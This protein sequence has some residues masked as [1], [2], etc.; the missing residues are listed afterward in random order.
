MHFHIRMTDESDNELKH[1]AHSTVYRSHEQALT[2]LAK[3]SAGTAVQLRLT[4]GRSVAESVG[5]TND[6]QLIMWTDKQ[7]KEQVRRVS[8]I[9]CE[10]H[11]PT[12]SAYAGNDAS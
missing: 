3:I 9:E 2:A 11:I 1:E 6:E 7:G 12:R 8:V 4:S 5:Q 10:K